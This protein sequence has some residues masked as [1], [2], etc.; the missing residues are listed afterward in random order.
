MRGR[1]ISRALE[2]KSWKNSESVISSTA[3]GK[4]TKN[5]TVKIKIEK[6]NDAIFTI[7]D[8]GSGID[9]DILPRIFTKFASKSKSGTGLGL[10]IS[11][12]IIEAHGGQI[13]AYNTNKGATFRFILPFANVSS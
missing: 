11:K 3:A 4:F 10:F 7:E 12:A 1:R 2:R 9:K 5:G 13:Q 6:N 8:T